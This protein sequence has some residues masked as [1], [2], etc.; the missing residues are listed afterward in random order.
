MVELEVKTITDSLTQYQ[1]NKG[2]DIEMFLQ[3]MVDFGYASNEHFI[4]L[5]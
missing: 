2:V 3:I 4:L 5:K 1:K